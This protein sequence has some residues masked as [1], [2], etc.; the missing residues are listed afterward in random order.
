MKRILYLHAGAELYGAD[1]VLLE[2]V[3]GLDKKEFKPIV[4]LPND[5]P[6]V[7]KLEENNIEVHIIKYP[8][9]RRKYFNPKG[10]I[11]Y[12]Y[13]Y[14]KYSKKLRMF[15]IEKDIDAIHINTAAVLEGSYLKKKTKL[16]IIWHIH[17][18]ITRP[19][20]VAKIIFRLVTKNADKVVCV[21]NAVRENIKE[22]CNTDY[23]KLEVIY[24]GVDNDKF[25]PNNEVDYLKKEFAIKQEELIV[26]M[27]GRVNAWKGQKDF[28]EALNIVFEKNKNKNIK[29]MLVGGVFEGQEWRMEE[30][31]EIIS[32]SRFSEKFILSD[33]RS[34]SSNIHNL[35]DVFVLPSTEPDPLPTVVLEAM[36]SAKPVVGYRHGGIC[37]MVKEGYNGILCEPSN[38]KELADAINRII[39]DKK[40]KET[41]SENSIKRQ[42]EMF[43]LKSYIKNFASLY[44][45]Y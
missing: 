1:I 5:G 27:I 19:K 6:L 44:S 8:I 30:L 37:E 18:I 24:N 15:C 22:I 12:I 13:N 23:S 34:D 20:I 36:A 21:S 28:V 43:S 11:S 17:E 7:K 4:V 32:K 25:K 31:K 35:F 33:F 2:L 38:K 26:G 9:L 29:A 10:I 39:N 3:K 41:Y 14:Y 42:R 45:N 16:P 40:I